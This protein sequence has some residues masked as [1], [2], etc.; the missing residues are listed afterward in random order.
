MKKPEKIWCRK[1]Q[2][3]GTYFYCYVDARFAMT[4]CIKQGYEINVEPPNDEHK[5]R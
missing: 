2:P 4:L 3:D 1:E 5:Y